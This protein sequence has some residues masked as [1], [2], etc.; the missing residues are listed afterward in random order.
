MM[1]DYEDYGK[2]PEAIY[3]AKF[4]FKGLFHDVSKKENKILVEIVIY[5]CTGVTFK[6]NSV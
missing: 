5:N 4:V 6:K 2:A 3:N 1:I